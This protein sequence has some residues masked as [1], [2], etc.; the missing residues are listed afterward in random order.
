MNFFYLMSELDIKYILR[1][2]IAERVI[3]AAENGDFEPC[4]EV[5]K[6]L[7]D[8]FTD[9]EFEQYSKITPLEDIVL[10]LT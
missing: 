9:E 1:N 8:P 4:R 7:A 2:Y 10:R 5:L 3:A 6:V